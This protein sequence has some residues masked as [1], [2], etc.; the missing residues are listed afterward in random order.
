MKPDPRESSQASLSDSFREGMSIPRV[1]LCGWVHLPSH[2]LMTKIDATE[3]RGVVQVL[4]RIEA[5][6]DEDIDKGLQRL[7][8]SWSVA[9]LDKVR[10]TLTLH[11]SV[12]SRWP[13]YYRAD[14][15]QLMW[16]SSMADFLANGVSLA[17]VDATV[18]PAIVLDARRPSSL[19][20]V[21]GVHRVAGGCTLTAVD[22][23]V[24]V[25]Q[26]DDFRFEP[27]YGVSLTRAAD[28]L[29][30]VLGHAVAQV[31]SR[32]DKAVT[33]LSGGVDSAVICSELSRQ[34]RDARAVTRTS[35]RV[36]EIAVNY[37]HARSVARWLHTPHSEL[38]TSVALDDGAS[39]LLAAGGCPML[40]LEDLTRSESLLC[41]KHIASTVGSCVV[42][43]GGFAEELFWFDPQCVIDSLGIRIFNPLDM[44]V[45]LWRTSRRF[46]QV[47]LKKVQRKYRPT[48]S[49][50]P[51]YWG[52]GDFEPWIT[53]SAVSLAKEIAHEADGE[54][55]IGL[56][57]SSAAVY[58]EVKHSLTLDEINHENL[59]A[60]APVGLVR[61]DPF[62]ERN[63][64]ELCLSLGPRHKVQLYEGQLI[65]KFLL[66]YAHIG[67]LPKEVLR[68]LTQVSHSVVFTRFCQAHLPIVGK[69]LGKN[70]LLGDLGIIDPRNVLALLEAGDFGRLR[71]ESPF[72]FRAAGME[73]W[74]RLFG[75]RPRWEEVV[76][77]DASLGSLMQEMVGT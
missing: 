37:K 47:L 22:G 54:F 71:R 17:S 62:A 7:E 5:L 34:A 44:D 29:R 61:V 77:S 6:L 21:K 66:R 35:S 70:S 16:S 42:A 75:A 1:A 2:A 15:E 4:R 76:H 19:S 72:L 65:R 48:A 56:P 43:S 41:A 23:E 53:G 63:L 27:K 50:L 58:D 10:S 60:Y 36:R 33:L 67:R 39:Y 31:V 51:T 13:L 40:A 26:V 32:D 68:A 3:K 8:G 55:D 52:E 9:Y 11:C 28:S 38:D 14:E 49:T 64:I 46:W 59:L 20:Y 45:P 30:E 25:S 57:V 73:L 12:T 24:A 69:L 18:L 74:L